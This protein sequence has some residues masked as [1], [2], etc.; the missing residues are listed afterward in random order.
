MSLVHVVHQSRAEVG[1][2]GFGVNAWRRADRLRRAEVALR[3]DQA[4]AHRPRLPHVNEGRVDDGLTVR[5]V[6]AAGVAADLGALHV[7]AAGVEGELLHGEEDAPLR[8]LQAVARI[9][10][11]AEMMTEHRVVE[12]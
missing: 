1:H 11:R 12:E 8:G 2:A 6:V 10:Q 4:F 7:L 3:I 9:G 5:V